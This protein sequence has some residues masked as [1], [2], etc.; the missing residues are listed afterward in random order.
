M[1]INKIF[2]THLTF[3]KK[4]SDAQ[5]MHQQRIQAEQALLNLRM[6]VSV[7]FFVPW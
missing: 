1:E 7:F 5:I 6:N 2:L 3:V 4:F